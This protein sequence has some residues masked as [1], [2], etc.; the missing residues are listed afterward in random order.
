MTFEV[1]RKF[2]L[3]VS[4][5]LAEVIR[6]DYPTVQFIHESVRDFLL[7]DGGLRQL[8]PT[9]ENLERQ[10]HVALKNICLRQLLISYEVDQ[11]RFKDYPFE[12]HA[13]SNVLS[14]VNHVHRLGLSQLTFLET[15]NKSN[16][17]A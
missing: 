12:R 14:Y 2:A 4:K 8:F 11:K 15:S 7:K 16:C 10:C 3:D 13:V 5:G 17:L 6:S 9:T 1:L